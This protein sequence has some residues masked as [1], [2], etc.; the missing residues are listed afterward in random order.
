MYG[1]IVV[2]EVLNLFIFY[3]KANC[4]DALFPLAAFLKAM[5]YSTNKCVK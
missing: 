4:V 2:E 3:G 1:A 5:A